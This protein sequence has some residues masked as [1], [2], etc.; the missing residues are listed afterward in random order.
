MSA[1]PPNQVLN[2]LYERRRPFLYSLAFASWA[3][4]SL[5]LYPLAFTSAPTRMNATLMAWTELSFSRHWLL[6]YLSDK[7]VAAGVPYSN[8]PVFQGW[9]YAIYHLTFNFLT[10]GRWPNGTTY[11]AATIALGWASWDV[12]RRHVER[13]QPLS[14]FIAI[15]V[16]AGVTATSSYVVGYL[17]TTNHDT[18]FPFV[19]AASTVLA[20][21][22][23]RADQTHPVTLWLALAISASTGLLGLTILV[24]CFYERE[25]LGVSSRWWL[26]LFLICIIGVLY[27][28]IIAKL[29]FKQSSASGILFRTG[30]DGSTQYFKTHLQAFFDPL[31]H[32]RK[33]ADLLGMKLFT[34]A[35]L[36]TF[37]YIAFR[38]TYLCALYALL[39]ASMPYFSHLVAFPQSVS[40]HPY[41]YDLLI[42]I[43]TDILIA[44]LF[45]ATI[46]SLQT[47]RKGAPVLILLAS[48]TLLIHSNLLRIA[49]ANFTP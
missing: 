44:L 8:M 23:I 43:P 38:R 32:Y 21:R 29:V 6:F 49:Q 40:I 46:G 35:C 24:L 16:A 12:I 15:W 11:I 33:V 2:W 3:L 19:A 48:S 47:V 39:L 41:L 5:R 13:L 37:S 30:L 45:C 20:F 7:D 17:S 14:A 4:V 18:V 22:I 9:L 28:M 34:I 36:L 27:P 1:A 42:V 31:F 26:A 10:A 25:K